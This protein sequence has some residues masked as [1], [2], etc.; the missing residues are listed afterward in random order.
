MQSFPSGWPG[1][2]TIR[3]NTSASPEIFSISVYKKIRQDVTYRGMNL[4][5]YREYCLSMGEDAGSIVLPPKVLNS[6]YVM[7]H[8]GT[9]GTLFKLK[10]GRASF[11]V[12]R[13]PA[14]ERLRNPRSWQLPS[15]YFWYRT[16]KRLQQLFLSWSGK[17]DYRSM[18][19]HLGRIDE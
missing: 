10:K 3:K 7:L 5:N 17:T 18:V 16:I 13:N 6:R 2:Q 12:K 11:Y 1:R 19:C 4:E 9:N 15:L 8:N 14:K